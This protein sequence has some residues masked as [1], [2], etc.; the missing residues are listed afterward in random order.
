MG[1]A[2]ELYSRLCHPCALCYAAVH[3]EHEELDQVVNDVVGRDIL[4]GRGRHGH[5]RIG[6][7]G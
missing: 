6:G 5:S 1:L 3:L 7:H 4:W 2:E